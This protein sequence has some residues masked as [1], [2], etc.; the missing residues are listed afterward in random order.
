M[1]L[2]YCAA[3]NARFRAL[4]TAF[5][6]QYG[7]QLPGTVYGPVCFADQDYKRPR[8]AAYMAALGR[9]GAA[10]RRRATA[11]GVRGVPASDE[12]AA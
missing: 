2:I 9:T 4:A 8:R 1:E 10:G 5:G 12:V 7:A 6:W 3:G 11:L